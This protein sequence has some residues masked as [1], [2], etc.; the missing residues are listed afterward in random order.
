MLDRAGQPEPVITDQRAITTVEEQVTP[1]VLPDRVTRI[2]QVVDPHVD[3]L[4]PWPP[5][6]VRM[7]DPGL[8]R[9]LR[10]QGVERRDVD[11]V[12]SLMLDEV[13]RPD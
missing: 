6:V 3:R 4:T 12:P 13:Q 5:H 10:I 11:E 2:D 1:P 8:E 7:D 9:T